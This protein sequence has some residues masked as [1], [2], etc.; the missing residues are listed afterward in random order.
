MTIQLLDKQHEMQ[1][2]KIQAAS[3]SGQINTRFFVFKLFDSANTLLKQTHKQSKIAGQYSKYCLGQDEK[4]R[5][6]SSKHV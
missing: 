1:H 4:L 2:N 3:L 6:Q 5:G